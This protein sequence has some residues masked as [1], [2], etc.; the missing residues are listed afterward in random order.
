MHLGTGIRDREKNIFQILDSW[1]KKALDPGSRIRINTNENFSSCKKNFV[2]NFNLRTGS[3][4]ANCR[5]H[6][7]LLHHDHRV[8]LL[9]HLHLHNVH[10]NRGVLRPR[11]ADCRTLNVNFASALHF[12][13]QKGPTPVHSMPQEVPQV[14]NT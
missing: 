5:P 3:W 2:C 8:R 14:L 10:E 13:L 7:H 4:R 12:F 6:L 9:L 11:R 1:V